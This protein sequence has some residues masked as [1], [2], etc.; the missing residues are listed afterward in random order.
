MQRQ[1]LQE[2]RG[3]IE[4]KGES[5]YPLIPAPNFTA[6]NSEV[7]TLKAFFVETPPIITWMLGGSAQR[8]HCGMVSGS[9]EAGRDPGWGKDKVAWK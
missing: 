4:S 7:W 9:L 6:Q 8:A 1:E 3:V 5:W 2:S